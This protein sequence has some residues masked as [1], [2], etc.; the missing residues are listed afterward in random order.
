METGHEIRALE[1]PKEESAVFNPSSPARKNAG[2]RI[3]ARKRA[4]KIV[5]DPRR[6]KNSVVRSRCF[7]LR[8]RLKKR[9]CSS[10]CPT[11]PR[12]KVNESPAMI[13]TRPRH[14][15]ATH[16]LMRFAHYAR[17]QESQLFWN[18]KADPAQHEDQ[19]C[20]NVKTVFYNLVRSIPTSANSTAGLA[21]RTVGAA[22]Y[23]TAMHLLRN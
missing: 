10:P 15:T 6:R 17:N 16:W 23:H 3:P 8:A 1:S 9:Y 2:A 20:A 13:P 11:A 7:L 4:M 21:L 19:K 22:D 12:K 14:T 5:F 18:R